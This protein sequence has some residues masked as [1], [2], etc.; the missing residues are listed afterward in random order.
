[1]CKA[2][3]LVPQQNSES[4]W[5][6]LCFLVYGLVLYM[7]K[8]HVYFCAVSI[9]EFFL[10]F[11][12]WKPLLSIVAFYSIEQANS[13]L[14]H[15]FQLCPMGQHTCS[16]QG[17]PQ[18]CMMVRG[19][20]SLLSFAPVVENWGTQVLYLQVDPAKHLPPRKWW[21]WVISCEPQVLC[22]ELSVLPGSKPSKSPDS[23]WMLSN[24]SAMG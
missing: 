18:M 19:T 6:F 3:G 10:F 12:H 8:V 23:F 9:L 16:L 24:V 17:V 21:D 5:S 2:P 11:V 20:K 22:S 14:L 15:R 13:P 7:V 1:M 4:I